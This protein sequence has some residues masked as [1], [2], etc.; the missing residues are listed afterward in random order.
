M[1]II[2]IIVPEQCGDRSVFFSFFANNKK[3]TFPKAYL[4]YFIELFYVLHNTKYQID[5]S[6]INDN[7]ETHC[8]R[9]S[10]PFE[11]KRTRRRKKKR[12]GR[13]RERVVEYT[14]TERC[15]CE[16]A[17]IEFESVYKPIIDNKSMKLD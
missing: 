16:S 11:L 14:D 4:R 7:F 10:T 1:N 5:A 8:S 17:R 13:E 2:I 15:V 3:I 12:D 9:Y 6:V